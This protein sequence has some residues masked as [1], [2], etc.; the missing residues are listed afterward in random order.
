MKLSIEELFL[1]TEAAEPEPMKREEILEQYQRAF[2]I[3]NRKLF[4]NELP[5]IE[6]DYPKGDPKEWG[7]GLACF[8]QYIDKSAP[9]YILLQFQDPPEWGISKDDINSLFHEL[10]H[11]YCYLH[12]IKDMD[13]DKDPQYH[14]KEF[15]RI[16][17]GYGATCE[18]TGDK[19][20]YSYT[21]LPDSILT[22]IFDEI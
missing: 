2:T 6:I 19:Y 14:N 18:Y 16:T 12:D 3:I 4:N 11:Y 9:P 13:R 15:K 1:D 20:G 22:E 7:E 21:N 17:E 10:I 5:P 8:I